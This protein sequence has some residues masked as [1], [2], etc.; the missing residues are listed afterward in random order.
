MKYAGKTFTLYASEPVA[1]QGSDSLYTYQNT[2]T[3][4]A[5]IVGSNN[6]VTW[7]AITTVTSGDS[8]TGS[9]AYAFLMM[10]GSTEVSV[11]RGAAGGNSFSSSNP[12]PVAQTDGLTVSGTVTGTEAYQATSGIPTVLFTTSMLNYESITVQ[13]TSAGTSCTVIYE[14]SEDQTIWYSVSGI[15]VT[16]AGAS[17]PSSGTT[18]VA[19]Y[20]FPRKGTYFRAR[21]STYSSPSTVSV[22]GTLSKTPVNLTVEAHL[23]GYANEGAT[24]TGQPVPVGLEGRTSSKTSVTSGQAVRPI[25]TVDGRLITRLNSIPENEWVYAAASGGITN[26]TTAATLVA[27]QA[28]GVRNYLTSLQLSSDVLGAATE[29]AIRD[30][31]G[32]TVL[33]RGKI[34]TAGIAGVSTIQFSDPLK[35][36]AATLLEVV[37]L[38]ASV[39]GGVYVNAQGYKAP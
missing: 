4:T 16:N 23:A 17:A 6:A 22:V 29:I 35:S 8:F 36:T 15:S 7:T 20:I 24:I 33:W 32:G 31:A 26:T 2:G 37:T 12:L 25:S 27:A 39:T 1:V 5:T 13:V 28:A 38:T 19:M 14:Q 11:S 18:L 3:G 10:T 9:H 30:G 21:V 34:G